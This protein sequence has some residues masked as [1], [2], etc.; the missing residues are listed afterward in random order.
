LETLVARKG[1][2][3]GKVFEAPE[4]GADHLSDPFGLGVPIVLLAWI[5]VASRSPT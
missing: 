2:E 1:K 3:K 4:L 5:C